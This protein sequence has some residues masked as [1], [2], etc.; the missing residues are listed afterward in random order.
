MPYKILDQNIT[1]MKVDAI[2]NPTDNYYGSGG[3][4]RAIYQAA[5]P[6]LFKERKK[7]GDIPPFEARITQGY[8]LPAKHVIHVVAPL[9]ND[10]KHSEEQTLE[11]TYLSAMSLAASHH[12]ESLAFPL[13]SSGMFGYSRSVDLTIALDSVRRFLEDHE[14]MIY[15][16]VNETDDSDDMMVNNSFEMP[17]KKPDNSKVLF[18]LA[19]PKSGHKEYDNKQQLLKEEVN[20]L[21]ETFSEAVLRMISERNL[22][23]SFIYKRANI[24]RKLFSKIR[25]NSDYQPSKITAIALAISLE[26]NIDETNILLAKAGYALS[27]SQKFDKVIIYFISSHNHDLFEIN[28]TLFSFGLKTIGLE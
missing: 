11:E 26:L 16:I 12:L 17:D 22:A 6:K 28:A 18:S 3:E 20:N 19:L 8:R 9:D 5:G 23:D 14:M 24:D 7:I 21:G 15:V 13:I 4:Q 1:T 27:T 2:V 25:S 10:S